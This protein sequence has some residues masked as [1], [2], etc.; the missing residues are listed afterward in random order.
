MPTRPGD[1]QALAQSPLQHP[2]DAGTAHGR[3]SSGLGAGRVPTAQELAAM[4]TR[5]SSYSLQPG[6]PQFRKW[7]DADL[8]EK[9]ADSLPE[10]QEMG[11]EGSLGSQLPR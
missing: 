9:L 11:S 5:T 2:N 1:G 7:E 10:V 6:T 8:Q 4:E 3:A